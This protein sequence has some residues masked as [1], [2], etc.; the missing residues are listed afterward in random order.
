MFRAI[1]D[2]YRNSPEQYPA[3][4]ALNDEFWSLL[5][6]A[7]FPIYELNN[8]LLEISAFESVMEELRTIANMQYVDFKGMVTGQTR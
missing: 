3:I 5:P 6:R 4:T 2:L 8:K 7:P 1:Q